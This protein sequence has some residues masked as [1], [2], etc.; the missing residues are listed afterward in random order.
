MDWEG[1]LQVSDFRTPYEEAA[2][3][4]FSTSPSTGS[5]EDDIKEA[6]F[7]AREFFDKPTETAT[8]APV[9]DT[10]LRQMA[11]DLAARQAV[12]ASTV[13]LAEKFL[14]FLKGGTKE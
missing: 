5:V 13:D 11:L 14:S 3:L 12:G 4:D 9:D 6:W 8:A 7:A 2:Y 1:D 10:H